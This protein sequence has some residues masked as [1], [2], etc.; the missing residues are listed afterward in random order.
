MNTSRNTTSAL[1]AAP[2][3]ALLLIVL[4][5]ILPQSAWAITYADWIASYG[6][7]GDAAAH[8]A[9][10]DGDGVPNLLEYALDG[11]SPIASD[12][13]TTTFV[14]GRRVL[15][16][17]PFANPA[18]IQFWG[19]TTTG[20]TYPPPGDALV[21]AGLR[22]RPRAATEGIRLSIEY[23]DPIQGLYRWFSGRSA[24]VIVPDTPV[25][26]DSVGWALQAFER[27]NLSRLFFRLRVDVI[28]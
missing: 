7:T 8:T 2:Q 25:A 13:A 27:A 16:D 17:L 10:P 4:L 23:S 18:A 3:L 19:D 11:M 5:A 1:V 14:F 9:D 24:V 26:G 6:L 28:P 12:T 22:F 21:H 20:R 15:D